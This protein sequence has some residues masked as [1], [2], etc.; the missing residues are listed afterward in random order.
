MDAPVPRTGIVG[1][2]RIG[3]PFAAKL[4]DAGYPVTGIDRG[5]VAELVEL[6]GE[7]LNGGTAGGVGEQSDILFT[8]LPSAEAFAEVISGNKGIARA[9]RVPRIVV[10]LGTTEVKTL[11]RESQVLEERG[12]QL[13]SCPV[14]G[15]PA[16]VASGAA[17]AFASGDKTAFES[18][19]DVIRAGIP[20]TT[21]VG[22]LGSGMYFK[23]VANLLVAV[24]CAAAAEAI[25]LAGV[26]GLD[27]QLLVELIS[28]SPG[29][30]S[31]QFNVRAPM[32]VAGDFPRLASVDLLCK[33]L[34][35]IE[36]FADEVGARTPTFSVAK[37]LFEEM[38]ARGEGDE[39]AARLSVMLEE[40]MGGENRDGWENK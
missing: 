38:S 30:T 31:G 21:Y 14:S 34:G 32:M 10:D 20:K 40:T 23:F 19:S 11:E 36:A 9:D 25:A 16:M 35:Q 7:V 33:D 18:S 24:H 3:L 5:R 15:T 17:T 8:C 4:L 13:L 27:R 1:I 39:D 22:R 26:A 28:A 2:G 12:C 29:A 6:G 37:R